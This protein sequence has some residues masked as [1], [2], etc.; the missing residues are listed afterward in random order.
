MRSF[1]QMDLDAL[2]AARSDDWNRLA[3]LAAKRSLSGAEA[4]ELIELY[5]SGASDLSSIRT[6]VGPTAHSERLSLSLSNARR[7][8]TGTPTN[9]LESFTKFFALDLP[10]ALYRVRW[11]TI[12]IVLGTAIVAVVMGVWLNANPSLLLHY[13]TKAQLKEY[14]D[15]QFTGY[16]SAHPAAAFAGE[17]WTHN[18]TLAAE[19][20]VLGIT[21]VGGIY[22]LLTNA[23]NIATAGAAVSQYGKPGDFWLSIAPH[24]QLE[25]YSLFTAGA[26]GLLL[27]WAWIA[28]G[29]RTRLEALAQDGRTF[30]IIGIG[31]IITLAM[32]GVIEGFV[33][34]QPW[35]WP[36]KIGIGTFALAIVLFYQWVV[37]RRAFRAG[38]TGD[39][40]EF[41]AGARSIV[42][43]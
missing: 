31:T 30:F 24:G 5:Q 9:V 42:A 26:A 6:A 32:S 1:K 2:A 16:Y 36:V 38:V 29:K 39:L 37:G 23:V 40:D 14:A 12:G 21:G 34:R 7:R 19:T 35:P 8:F 13:M 10:A 43:G 11:V 41:E 3:R 20:I 22:L 18:A 33:V 4:D 27:F 17:V 25:L 28:P 15:E